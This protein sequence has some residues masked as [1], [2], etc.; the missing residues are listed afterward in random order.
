MR[1][2]SDMRMRWSG[3]MQ[4]SA[5]SNA[6]YKR[7]PVKDEQKLFQFLRKKAKYKTINPVAV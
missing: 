5:N 2:T 1:L 6:I 4:Y 3:W 7:T